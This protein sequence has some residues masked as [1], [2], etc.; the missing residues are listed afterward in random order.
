[1]YNKNVVLISSII[2]TPNNPLSY[3]DTRSVFSH[4]DRFEQT[5]KTIQTIRNKIS[6]PVILMVECSQL[7]DDMERYLRNNTDV[8]LNMYENVD[9]RANIYSESKS[10][11]ESTQVIHGLQYVMEHMDTST[12]ANIIKIS[13]RY[14]LSD[15]FDEMLFSSNTWVVKPINGKRNNVFTALYKLPITDVP[16]YLRY[17][18]SSDSEFRKCVGLEV[19]FA[20]FINTISNENCTFVERIGLDGFVSING[21]AYSG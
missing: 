8:F 4:Y 18:I 7:S 17:L 12:I 15:T 13:G 11:G 14:W 3:T 21:N 1:M 2:N 6:T 16:Q 20:S 19:N 9:M 10:L 5:K